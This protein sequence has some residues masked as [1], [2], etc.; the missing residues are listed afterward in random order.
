[1]SSPNSTRRGHS[2]ATHKSNVI[3][4]P[5][6]PRVVETDRTEYPDTFGRVLA[7]HLKQNSI[8]ADNAYIPFRLIRRSAPVGLILIGLGTAVAVIYQLL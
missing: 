8:D 5:T 1:M 6:K 7:M 2:V 4:F 3:P